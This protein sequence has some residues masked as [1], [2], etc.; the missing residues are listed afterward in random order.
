MRLCMTIKTKY[1]L[2]LTPTGSYQS[3]GR[4]HYECRL[5]P[6]MIYRYR[7]NYSLGGRIYRLNRRSWFYK[8][9]TVRR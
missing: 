3:A 6:K 9:D 2:F 1:S 8:N 7:I 5:V 4:A